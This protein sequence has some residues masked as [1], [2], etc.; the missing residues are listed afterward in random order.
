MDPSQITDE[1]FYTP[2]ATASTARST[3][4]FYSPRSEQFSAR[5]A[6]GFG[7]SSSSENEYITPRYNLHHQPHSYNTMNTTSLQSMH[8]SS[9]DGHGRAGPSRQPGNWNRPRVPLHV[10]TRLEASMNQSEN[11]WEFIGSSSQFIPPP[12]GDAER[13]EMQMNQDNLVY[14][15]GEV[16]KKDVQ[17]IFSFTR[18]G[19]ADKVDALLQKGVNINSRDENG[20]TILA[21]ACQNGN[22]RLV[23]VALRYGAQINACNFKGNT[24][25]HFCCRYGY[26]ETLGSYL[27]GKGADK[28]IRNM[29]GCTP[30]DLAR[31]T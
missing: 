10:D 14:P 28:K 29:D 7:G 15:S 30:E 19:R 12:H 24:A 26:S 1:R 3:S 17:D 16:N 8:P 22:K 9:W 20:N 6:G 5:S 27:I 23:K 21:V 13:Q 4:S 11:N 25:L 18:H 31:G 2:R